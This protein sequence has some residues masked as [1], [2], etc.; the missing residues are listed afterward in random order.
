MRGVGH[1]GNRALPVVVA[2]TRLKE[3]RIAIRSDIC[4]FAS[5][6]N[7]ATNSQV[8]HRR[9]PS[10]DVNRY[11]FRRIVSA[12]LCCAALALGVPAQAE[13]EEVI[14]LAVTLDAPDEV[15][16]LLERHL[17]ILRPAQTAPTQKIDAE[18]L[19]RRTR[20]DVEN[21]LATEG[22]FTPTIDVQRDS[23][24]SWH[25]VVEPGRRTTVESVDITFSG[26]ITRENEALAARR[27]AAREEWGLNAGQPFTQSAWGGAKSDLLHSVSSRDYAAAR[28][29]HS[30]AAIDPERAT[31]ALSITVDSGP[32]F[33]LG[34]VR[35]RGYERLPEG[36]AHRYS[37]LEPGEPYDQE[38]LL[39]YQSALQEAP[40]FGSVVVEI[41][42]DPELADAVPVD[43]QITEADSRR[44]GFGAGF[45]T[46]TGARVETNWR[47]VNLFGRAWE[48]QTGLRIEQRRQAFYGDLFLPPPRPGVRDGFGWVLEASD[49]EGLERDRA[50]V[51][52]SRIYTYGD[53]ET[54][55]MLRYE[56]EKLRP[57]DGESSESTALSANVS[58][59]LRRVDD[60]FNPRRGYVLHGAL[61]GG[62]KS[63]LSDQDFLRVYGRGV[64]YQP[65]GAH[66]VVILR[67]EL[68]NTF[69]DSS[70][71]VPMSFLFRTGGSQTVR[72]YAYESLGVEDGDAVLGG[73]FLATASAEYVHWI[74]G[75][76]WGVASFVDV[77][78]ASETRS[79]FDAKLG[80]GAG[81][82]WRSP[83]GPLA[84]DLAWGHDKQKLRVHFSVAIAF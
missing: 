78:D 20:R 37:R 48:L 66:D 8:A 70:D 23:V 79:D 44:L 62:A 65:V 14:P 31:A 72:G 84:L 10:M 43:V 81:M 7:V 74:N 12:A 64:L 73:R 63:V 3:C 83:A 52:A 41:P 77:G 51:G 26:D 25:L 60:L 80:Y 57:D 58:H 49:I 39:A 6:E 21:L 29:V 9:M 5:S 30:R 56:T 61:G 32:P 16:A 69:A 1:D 22:Y 68:G 27:S 50:A 45:S 13:E 15:S 59:T 35:V 18:S 34:E 19:V 11:P 47:D 55:L 46:N 54:T 40:Q 82:R 42:R 36:L 4:C 33:K 2:P 67:G 24:Q 71:G 38:R 53:N 28:I 76:P 75:G 17:R